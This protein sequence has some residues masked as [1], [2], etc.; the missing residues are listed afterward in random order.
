MV[1]FV[2]ENCQ[3]TVK[4]P[5]LAVHSRKCRGSK[6][7]CIDCYAIF[8]AQNSHTS[9]ITEVQKFQK[10][11]NIKQTK[12]INVA[13]PLLGGGLISQ[14][15]EQVL[16]AKTQPNETKALQPNETVDNQQSDARKALLRILKKPRTMSSFK[17]KTSKKGILD[18]MLEV[19]F[20][21]KDI[22]LKVK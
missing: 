21:G 8:P 17:R 22:V 5:K 14:L 11:D 3:E 13:L 16:A 6:Y 9:C 10:N 1:S 4:K 2:C 19:S 15:K 18:S 12:P 7:S 20:N